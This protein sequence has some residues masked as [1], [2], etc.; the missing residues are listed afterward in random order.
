MRYN[1][2]VGGKRAKYTE[3]Q[4]QT[5]LPDKQMM[6]ITKFRSLRKKSDE[7]KKR[8]DRKQ[9]YT[10]PFVTGNNRPKKTKKNSRRRW[11]NC[12]KEKKTRAGQKRKHENECAHEAH[13]CDRRRGYKSF[14]LPGTPT[15][16]RNNGRRNETK[17]LFP[18]T[19]RGEDPFSN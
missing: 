10:T 16:L 18:H 1:S 9:Y 8:M 11:H 14:L 12:A 3:I 6:Q 19:R 15:G 2:L 5:E 7:K 17:R 4:T 13:H